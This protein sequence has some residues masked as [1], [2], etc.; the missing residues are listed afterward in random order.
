M[1]ITFGELVAFV[2]VLLVVLGLVV[3]VVANNSS[4]RKQLYARLD[5]DRLRQE[6]AYTSKDICKIQHQYIKETLDEI[7]LFMKEISA[8]LDRVR[9]QLKT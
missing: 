2:G 6:D 3:K 1:T 5:A 7:K 4:Q 9:S 8:V